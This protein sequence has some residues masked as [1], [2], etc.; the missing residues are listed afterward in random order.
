MNIRPHEVNTPSEFKPVE[1]ARH[2][3]VCEEHH[4]L[5]MTIQYGQTGSAALRFDDLEASGFKHCGCV[6]AYERFV[7]NN[8]NSEVACFG[9]QEGHV[10]HLGYS[11]GGL[12]REGLNPLSPAS[13]GLGPRY[14]PYVSQSARFR[15]GAIRDL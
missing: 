9:A 7:V 15:F 1:V 2:I 6:H 12:R 10:G 5:R 4:D 3:D 8:E 14:K 13:D 11:F